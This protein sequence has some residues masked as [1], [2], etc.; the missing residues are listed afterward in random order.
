M[1]EI[2]PKAKE[3]RSWHEIPLKVKEIRSRHKVDTGSVGDRIY[4][5]ELAKCEVR[6]RVL[7]KNNFLIFQPKHILW[8]L[9]KPSQW[10]KPSSKIFY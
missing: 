8:V 7:Q 3:I 1:I 2:L 5:G 10:L 9:K 4:Q 6:V